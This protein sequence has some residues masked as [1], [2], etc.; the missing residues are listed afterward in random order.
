M[1]LDEG[2]TYRTDADRVKPARPWTKQVS[3]VP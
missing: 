3:T 2:N 1:G